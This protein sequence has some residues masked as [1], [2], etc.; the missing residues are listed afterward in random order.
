M[1]N[2]KPSIIGLVVLILLFVLAFGGYFAYN[3]Y[4]SKYVVEERSVET[5]GFGRYE[6]RIFDGVTYYKRTGITT[7]LIM[8]VDRDTSEEMVGYRMGGQADFQMLLVLDHERKEIHTFQI[9]RD[10]MTTFTQLTA[11]GKPVTSKPLQICLAHAYGE[12]QAACA[13]NQVDAVEKL[14]PGLKIDLYMAF[15]YNA[16]PIINDMLGGITVTLEDDFT[17][18]DPEMVQGRT[19]TLKGKQAEHFVRSRMSVGDGTN[20]SRQK[21]QRVWIDGAI[22]RIEE[23]TKE[24]SSFVN[25]MYEQLGRRLTTNMSEG[26][27]I[28]EFNAAYNY[29]RLPLE[30]LEGEHYATDYM[31]FHPT[32][33]SKTRWIKNTYYRLASE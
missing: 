26:R 15:D 19:I 25:K 10:T 11:S 5:P 32:D 12:S 24:D 8:G 3:W 17:G 7:I 21:R 31:E 6:E 14:L 16:V 4:Q 1:R 13:L 27:L 29:T 33:E 2:R 30:E 23:C 20:V 9:D 18:A 28:N 22:K